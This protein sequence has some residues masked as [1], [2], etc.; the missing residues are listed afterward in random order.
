[1]NPPNFTTEKHH[2]AVW[3]KSIEAGCFPQWLNG[4]LGIAWH[5]RCADY[6]HSI[7]SQ[8]TTSVFYKKEYR[9]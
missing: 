8:C 9:L 1:M 5:C 7:D 6:K 3:M 2:D 4:I